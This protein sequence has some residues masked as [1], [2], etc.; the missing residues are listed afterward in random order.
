MTMW[1]YGVK[2]VG[3]MHAEDSLG[4]QEIVDWVDSYVSRLPGASSIR[5]KV[6]ADSDR[7]PTLEDQPTEWAYEKACEAR[8]KHRARADEAEVKLFLIRLELDGMVD[9]PGP[10]LNILDGNED[11]PTTCKCSKCYTIP[12]MHVCDQCGSKRCIRAMDHKYSCVKERDG[13]GE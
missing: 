2:I 4:E 5:V 1:N 13:R 3:K 10:I 6:E 11:S 7:E 12:I 9:A 8:E